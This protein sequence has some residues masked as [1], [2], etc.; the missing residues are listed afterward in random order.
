M[1]LVD[2][3]VG[4]PTRTAEE[5]GKIV[6][7]AV[8]PGA[9]A[10]VDES[11]VE[12]VA[13]TVLGRGENPPDFALEVFVRISIGSQTHDLVFPVIG[14][15]PQILGE[16]GV[17]P[18][19]RVGH[20]VF[21]DRP[22]FIA[23]AGPQHGAVL[24][25]GPVDRHTQGV[26]ERR[27]QIGVERVHVVV[28]QGIDRR[29]GDVAELVPP[30]SGMARLHGRPAEVVEHAPLPRLG[31]V[32]ERPV[33][34][35]L[36]EEA[37]HNAVAI[38]VAVPVDANGRH[39]LRADS[40]LIEAELQGPQGIDPVGM[41]LPREAFLFGIGQYPAPLNNSDGRVEMTLEY[42]EIDRGVIACR[43]FDKTPLY[44]IVPT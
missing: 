41:L 24:I 42:T 18:A 35:H 3:L 26:I 40:G 31:P 11:G 25:A 19:E 38:G 33:L 30:G 28:G 16:G 32:V 39:I 34:L 12:P 8:R 5:H 43:H 2:W 44:S 21:V 29:H 13:D 14:L 37:P 1:P 9:F 23:P 36:R 15:E 27:L 7:K 6:G 17:E 4:Q 22:D 10:V 20:Q